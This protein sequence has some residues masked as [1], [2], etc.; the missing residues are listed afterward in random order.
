MGKQDNIIKITLIQYDIK[1]ESTKENLDKLS[2]MIADS[3]YSSDLIL[4]PEM[5]NTGFSMNPQKISTTMKGEVV[6]WMKET[7]SAYKSVIAGSS[8]ICEN[9]KYYNRFLVAYPSG[10]VQ[11][12][13][14]RHLFRMSDEDKVYTS[15]NRRIVVN[16]K[17]WRC[18]LFICYDIRFPVWTRN[19]GNYDLALYVANWPVNR[20][21]VWKTLL[22]AR[23]LENQCYVAGVNRTGDAQDISYNGNS[24]VFDYKGSIAASLPESTEGVMNAELSLNKLNDFR[25]SFPVWMDADS[26]TICN[27]MSF[28]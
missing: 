20:I 13:D 2:L 28:T 6:G 5:F 14:K 24:L 12:C 1:W 18:V 25:E 19:T 21:D 23:A 9:E 8:V 17:G 4:L 7:A 16:V 3:N 10:D 11:W 22:K 26:F 27:S 15:G